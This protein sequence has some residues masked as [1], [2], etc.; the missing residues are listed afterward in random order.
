MRDIRGNSKLLMESYWKQS[1]KMPKDNE[2]IQ[3]IA[4]YLLN[5]IYLFYACSIDVYS[6][7]F[8]HY[9]FSIGTA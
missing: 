6:I 9:K 7:N 5:C 1:E 2:I 8:R 3:G 4:T